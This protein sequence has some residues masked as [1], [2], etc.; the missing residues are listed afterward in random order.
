ML[1]FPAALLTCLLALTAL[2][3]AQSPTPD[4]IEN[5]CLTI[6][7]DWPV[8]GGLKG[9]QLDTQV[10]G[11][12]LGLAFAR[13]NASDTR[14]LSAVFASNFR[15]FLDLQTPRM[16]NNVNFT[17]IQTFKDRYGC[18]NYTHH[19]RRYLISMWCVDS[20]Y[21]STRC[22]ANSAR[23]PLCRETCNTYAESSIESFSNSTQC[24]PQ[25]VN[26]A[27]TN[28]ATE[29]RS[30]C[31]REMFNGR[32]P[33]CISGREI[34][35]PTCGYLL[36]SRFCDPSTCP[37]ATTFCAQRFGIRNTA[38]TTLPGS[39]PEAT[40]SASAD[41]QSQSDGA[42]PAPI[43]PIILGSALA[44]L[45]LLVGAMYFWRWRVDK[46]RRERYME[47]FSNRPTPGGANSSVK[48]SEPSWIQEENPPPMPPMSQV[49]HAGYANVPPQ[50]PYAP[51]QQQQQPQQQQPAQ[52]GNQGQQDSQQYGA[53]WMV[54]NAGGAAAGAQGQQQDQRG[55]FS[56]PQ[57]SPYTPNNPMSGYP[58]QQQQQQQQAQYAQSN[59][60]S[61]VSTTK[62]N[63]RISSM[64][65][66][67]N[68]SITEL[69]RASLALDDSQQ[70]LHQSLDK[71]LPA[72][73]SLPANG[74]AAP[75]VTEYD[76]P[77]QHRAVRNY[78]PQME[79][80]LELLVGDVVAVSQQYDDGW[81]FGLNLATGQVGVLPLGFVTPVDSELDVG[82]VQARQ[83]IYGD[84]D[85]LREVR[86]QAAKAAVAS[87]P[88][89]P[90]QQDH[91]GSSAA[92]VA[93]SSKAAAGANASAEPGSPMLVDTSRV[94][95]SGAMQTARDTVFLGDDDDDVVYNS[96]SSGNQANKHKSEKVDIDTLMEV[97]YRIARSDRESRILA[98]LNVDFNALEKKDPNARQ[99]IMSQIERERALAQS[100]AM[101]EASVD[102]KRFSFSALLDVL[103]DAAGSDDE[104]ADVDPDTLANTLLNSYNIGVAVPPESAATTSSALGGSG[105]SKPS[106]ASHGGFTPLPYPSALGSQSQPPTGPSPYGSHV[107][108][109]ELRPMSTLSDLDRLESMLNKEEEM[110]RKMRS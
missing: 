107:Q 5:G 104:D 65:V 76:R 102:S 21:A 6:Q 12:F 34:E 41:G 47:G 17:Y 2:A 80:E 88:L 64:I 25:T 84:P 103:N 67:K 40:K 7:A 50:S 52:L 57:Q 42:T 81:G 78:A 18:P 10:Q 95:V 51:Q 44:L 24:P 68:V 3:Q 73:P 30:F 91:E 26:T 74:T 46:R 83:S 9:L 79:D 70:P 39:G 43:V 8:C 77:V 62:A 4:V 37:E 56:Q 72:I 19:H 54:N 63:K 108:Q 97:L 71:N 1:F 101:S 32:E 53:Y 90:I 38:A 22:P 85:K 35:N 60:G 49:N 110:L 55:N 33:N 106:A 94:S 11:S 98:D 96:T 89:S 27:R 36:T 31:D 99:S 82:K 14:P 61:N 69:L 13:A 66:D 15:D 105:A 45:V 48:P 20:V 16:P 87:V 100:D 75:P 58:T 109:D 28:G 86:E 23:R 93:S 92:T 59:V 29:I